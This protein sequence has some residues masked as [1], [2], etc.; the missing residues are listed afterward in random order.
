MLFSPSVTEG[1][2]TLPSEIPQELD[3]EDRHRTMSLS[4]QGSMAWE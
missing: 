1:G 3:T 2:W 4:D